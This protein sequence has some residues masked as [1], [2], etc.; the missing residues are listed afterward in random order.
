MIILAL[1]MGV[2]VLAFGLRMGKWVLKFIYELA[3]WVIL[4]AVCMALILTLDKH[5]QEATNGTQQA[6]TK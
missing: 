3:P 5:E 2:F 6:Q 1:L 4:L